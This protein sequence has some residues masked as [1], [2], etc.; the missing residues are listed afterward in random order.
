M[1]RGHEFLAVQ[2]A[3]KFRDLREK[4]TPLRD[5]GFS[6]FAAFV[7]A[8]IF[9]NAANS[10]SSFTLSIKRKGQKQ[11]ARFFLLQEII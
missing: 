7:L 2:T 3:A 10:P 1:R 4:P 6:L 9:I 8:H 5:V 11:K